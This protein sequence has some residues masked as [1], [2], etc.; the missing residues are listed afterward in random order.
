[1]FLF[2]KRFFFKFSNDI[3]TVSLWK[4]EN[5]ISEEKTPIEMNEIQE[6]KGF[7]RATIFY[8]TQTGTSKRQALKIASGIRQF[9]Q[10]SLVDVKDVRELN[11]DVD[12]Q[13]LQWPSNHAILF[14]LA[15]YTDGQPPESAQW[16]YRWLEDT[17]F[18]FRVQKT[19]L[20]RMHYAVFGLGA[21]I[22]GDNYGKVGR[23]V[24]S[25]LHGL[26]AHRLAPLRLGDVQEDL[27]ST[28]VEWTQM[29]LDSLNLESEKLK[30]K[31]NF[32]SKDDEEEEWNE[33]D[34]DEAIESDSAQNDVMD[35]E[36]LGH[37]AGKLTEAVRQRR[38]QP[39][40]M[41]AKKT[42]GDTTVPEPKAMVTPTLEASLTKQGYKI[43]GSH[44][45]VKVCRWTKSMLR[46]RG[47]CY[48]HTF[49]GIASHQCM[50][51]TPSL[52]CGKP[53]FFHP[54]KLLS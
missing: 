32:E 45:G 16:F 48:K 43:I 8:A 37:V 22:Y 20:H 7:D 53:L 42:I 35:L 47:G 36:D 39:L 46:G 40:N 38:N 9:A 49:Y 25:W 19:A 2:K 34:E 23:N 52:A 26:G 6:F 21:C 29:V 24:D 27:D 3:N 5:K 17:R 31:K 28:F 30:E 33:T 54:T 4:S 50:E 10:I 1:V 13:L 18:D 14:I 41:G 44:S 51:T 15:T 12:N 11:D